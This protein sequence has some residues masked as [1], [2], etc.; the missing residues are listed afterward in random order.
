MRVFERIVVMPS[1]GLRNGVADPTRR[2]RR[3]LFKG[4]PIWPWFHLQITPRTCRGPLPI[5][6]DLKPDPPDG[7][8][9]ELPAGIWCGPVSPHFGHM[10]ADFGMR[11][12]AAAGRAGPDL[13]LVFSFWPGDEPPPGFFP[14]LL[15]HFRVPPAHVVLVRQPT[16]VQRLQVEPQAERLFGGGPSRR[17][18][19]LMDAVTA[20]HGPPGPALDTLFV[21]RSGLPD[22]R[23]AGEAYLDRVLAAA[24]ATVLHPEA[25]ELSVQLGLY[26][27]ARRLIFSEGSALH[28]LQLLG[29]LDADVLVILRRARRRTAASALRPRV[30]S[31]AYLNVGCGSIF[32]L[33]GRGRQQTD[34]ALI[35]FDENRLASRLAEWL[36]RP[37]ALPWD[38][39]SYRSERDEDIRRWMAYMRLLDL[40]P[41]A[42]ATI[43]AC[44]R[45]NGLGLPASEG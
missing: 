36:G 41:D 22:G 37:A 23:L 2:L 7:R 9:Q 5:P 30:K 31:L 38:A 4:G 19:D 16:L 40:H 8:V 34:R 32:G 24:G 25:T 3:G 39:G 14:Q 44:L 11:I 12:A 45:R 20:A 42:G 28:A 35:L 26:R 27:R 21:S 43:Q 1:Q 18:L 6:A 15:A 17:H 33:D 13:P 29:R 10:V